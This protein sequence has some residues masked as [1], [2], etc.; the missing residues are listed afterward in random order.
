MVCKTNS[1]DRLKKCFAAI[2]LHLKLS[3]APS[4]VHFAGNRLRKCNPGYD[5]DHISNKAYNSQIKTQSFPWAPVD[6]LWGESSNIAVQNLEKRIHRIGVRHVKLCKHASM[7]IHNFQSE[8]FWETKGLP[9]LMCSKTHF[10][11]DGRGMKDSI[12]S[13]QS[14]QMCSNTHNLETTIYCQKLFSTERIQIHFPSMIVK[15][16]HYQ[17]YQ[18]LKTCLVFLRH[19]YCQDFSWYDSTSKKIRSWHSYRLWFNC[20]QANLFSFTYHCPV[21]H[22]PRLNPLKY[23]VVQKR[24]FKTVKQ[25]SI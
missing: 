19:W 22:R 9:M 21:V 12:V 18:R 14:T 2:R 15:Y 5:Q 11:S 20:M 1:N 8:Y 7:I 24:H 16:I 10:C 3:R 17:L 4:S 23:R 25:R 13:I 6:E